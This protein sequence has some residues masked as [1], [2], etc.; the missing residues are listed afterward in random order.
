MATAAAIREG[1]A[2]NLAPIPNMQISAYLLGSP[3]PPAIEIVPDG[4]TY[5]LA[6]ARGLDEWKFVVRAFV[7]FTSDIGAQKRLDLMLASSGS[8]SVKAAIESAPTLGGACDD[9][10]VTAVS[11]YRQ[12]ARDGGNPVIG[13]EWQVEVFATG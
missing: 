6:L 2:A 9:L 3:T 11:G 1:I 7:G 5:D 13:A 4:V 10:R 12:W 8:N